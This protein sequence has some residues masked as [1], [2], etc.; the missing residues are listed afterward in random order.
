MQAELCWN[1]QAFPQAKPPIAPAV[2]CA[3]LPQ[4]RLQVKADGWVVK[5]LDSQPRDR[6]FESRHTLGIM[7][8]KSLG[9]ICTLTV[10]WGDR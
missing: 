4:L 10:P 6:R 9:K 3:L 5:V 1:V 7:C 2:R 8:L